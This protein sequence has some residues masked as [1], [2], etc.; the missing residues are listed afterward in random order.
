MPDAPATVDEARA[1]LQTLLFQIKEGSD[2]A[3]RE[4]V[5]E[6]GP[7]ILRVVRSRLNKKLRSKFDSVDFTQSVWAS[8]FANRTVLASLPGPEAIIGYLTELARSKVGQEHRRRFGLQ[9]HDIRR[10]EPLALHALG[11][12]Q[13][14]N[15]AGNDPTP[16]EVVCQQETWENLQRQMPT[17]ERRLL[18]FLREGRTLREVAKVLGVSERT[19]QRVFHKLK[20][21]TAQ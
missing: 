12:E 21:R 7:I 17:D 1:R 6:Y 20:T 18:E 19:I 13:N 3:A 15:I 5:E 8:F 11:S 10:E 4:L 16:S 2:K 9:K 14:P